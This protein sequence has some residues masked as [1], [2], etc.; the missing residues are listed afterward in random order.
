MQL[1]SLVKE[2]ISSGSHNTLELC[3][4]PPDL[5]TAKR[6]ANWDWQQMAFPYHT[7]VLFVV[8]APCRNHTLTYWISDLIQTCS[9]RHLT[10]LSNRW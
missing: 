1:P 7:L 6:F 10:A 4:K 5:L 8:K 2:P 9:W 3:S